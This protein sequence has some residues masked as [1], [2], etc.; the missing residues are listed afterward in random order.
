MSY[1]S[2]AKMQSELAF[3]PP[4]Q[5]QVRSSTRMGIKVSLDIVSFDCL[6]V[7]RE[8]SLIQKLR[9]LVYWTCH[10]HYAY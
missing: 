10:F 4:V 3:L 2:S 1:V 5:S 7:E 9:M 8:E 6:S